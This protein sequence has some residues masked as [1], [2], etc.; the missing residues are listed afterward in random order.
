MGCTSS[1]EAV[2]IST[3]SDQG[4]EKHTAEPKASFS[5]TPPKVPGMY[6]NINHSQLK[7]STTISMCHFGW[8][9]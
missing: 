2:S 8:Q 5:I 1:R 3:P 4:T 6:V 7:M 9:L